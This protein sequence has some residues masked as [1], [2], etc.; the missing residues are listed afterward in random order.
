V[1][2]LIAEIIEHAPEL[3]E[4]AGMAWP[5]LKWTLLALVIGTVLVSRAARRYGWTGRLGRVATWAGEF[6][7]RRARESERDFAGTVLAIGVLFSAAALFVA[8][9]RS[10]LV[11]A[12]ALLTL[13]GVARVTLPAWRRWWGRLD[14]AVHA[15]A[16]A[17]P[18]ADP[19]REETARHAGPASTP[20]EVRSAR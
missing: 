16:A 2:R 18:P 11:G 4:L 20:L 12:V 5:V 3:A 1:R 9:H 17:A 15:A 19:T 13:G 8:F 6:H 10:I 14:A 7:E